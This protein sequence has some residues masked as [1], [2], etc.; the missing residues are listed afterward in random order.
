[1]YK[2]VILVE[3]LQDWDRFE[4]RWPEFL[5]LV[6]SLPGLRREATSRVEVFLYG[7][8]PYVHMHELFFDSRADAEKALTSP[9]GQ[10]AGA[11]LQQMSGGEMT[12]F[13]ADHRED[14]LAHIQ[15]YKQA[16]GETG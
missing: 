11:L 4:E 13:F 9:D 14:D 5:H 2:L 3:S 7:A 16:G 1:M 10:A 8:K 12:L 15:K 6:E